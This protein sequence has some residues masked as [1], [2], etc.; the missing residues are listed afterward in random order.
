MGPLHS[1]DGELL[2]AFCA[3][4]LARLSRAFASW[5]PDVESRAIARD[6]LESLLTGHAHGQLGSEGFNLS[7]HNQETILFTIGPYYGNLNLN[8]LT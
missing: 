2:Q 5:F 1:C 4:T 6:C 7:Y 3:Q 8:S